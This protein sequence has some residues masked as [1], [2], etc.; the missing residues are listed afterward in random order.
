MTQDKAVGI[1]NAYVENHPELGRVL[2]ATRVV[3]MPARYR[4]RANARSDAWV[5]AYPYVLP[6]GV[7]YQEPDELGVEVDC[8]TGEVSIPRML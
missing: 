8:E 6:E 4:S 3:L 2:R 7:E 5:V 1:A